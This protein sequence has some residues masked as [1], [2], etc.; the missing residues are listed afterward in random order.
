[1]A[2][3]ITLEHFSQKKKAHEP[4]T[5]VTAYDF[6]FARIFDEAGADIILVG[7]SLAN[8][9]LGLESTKEIGIA[10]MVHHAKAVG[11]AVKRAFVVGDMPYSSYQVAGADT[12]GDAKQLIAAGCDAVKVE[13]FS[14]C[15]EVVAQL[16]GAG[17]S[18]MGHIGLTPQ[19]VDELGGYKV[20]G[21]TAE[22]A[23]RLYEEALALELAGC[24]SMVLEC[25]PDRVAALISRKLN[26]FTI[27]IGAGP[28]C[29]GQVLVLHDMLGL[30]SGKTAKFVKQFSQ[31]GQEVEKGV[32]A[33]LAQ[34]SSRQYPSQEQVYHID[35]RELQ[36]FVNRVES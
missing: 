24:F 33:Y 30:S 25:V 21:K 13:W 17:I 6:P 7:D 36:T 23:Q 27:G 10:E 34:V 11:R 4:I 22:A 5:V 12:V 28:D 14:G 32:R 1:M 26:A 29:D 2:H 8:V 35:D 9:V 31:V 18:V 15:L 20:Q 3:P 16:R 19:T